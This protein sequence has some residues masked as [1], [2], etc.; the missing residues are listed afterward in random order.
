MLYVSKTSSYQYPT[1]SIF[2][3][4]DD[5][6]YQRFEDTYVE[7][8]PSACSPSPVPRG[9]V[10]PQRG[11]NKVWC[12][13]AGAQVRERLGWAIEPEKGG[14][15]RLA[16]VRPRRHVLDSREQPDL[17]S[18]RDFAE[19]RARPPL[20]GVHRHL[21]AL[22]AGPESDKGRCPSRDGRPLAV[23]RGAPAHLRP[24]Y[25]LPR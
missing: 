12:E 8:R 1:P 19:R 4:F 14:A 23:S 25:S 18:H 11:F 2:V 20:A 15:G 7:G 5:G 24:F 22:A 13:G 10:L 3:L 9:F 6:T 17:R 21:P 16:A